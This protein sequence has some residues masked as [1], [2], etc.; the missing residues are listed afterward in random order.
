M[1]INFENEVNQEAIEKM[2]K[3]FGDPVAADGKQFLFDR[4]QE[5]KQSDMK[6]IVNAAK[7]PAA[8]E[9]HGEGEIKT[10]ADG[11]RYEVTPTGWRKLPE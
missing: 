7:Q 8:V 10:M 3:A 1:S 9:L 4:M 6:A 11:T 2:R 5:I